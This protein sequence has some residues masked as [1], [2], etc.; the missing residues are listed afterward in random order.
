M[1]RPGKRGLS[2]L[3]RQVSNNGFLLAKNWIHGQLTDLFGGVG[4]IGGSICD[5]DPDKCNRLEIPKGVCRALVFSYN[6]FQCAHMVL[7]LMLKKNNLS[8][9]Y[10]NDKSIR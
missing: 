4:F 3:V 2:E 10:I 6:Q 9:K 8:Y 7:F 5:C 1:G